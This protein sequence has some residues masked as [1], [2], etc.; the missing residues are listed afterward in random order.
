MI[1]G[2]LGFAMLNALFAVT[3]LLPI[4]A[5]WLQRDALTRRRATENPWAS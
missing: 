2:T 1:L 4:A 5:S 3:L